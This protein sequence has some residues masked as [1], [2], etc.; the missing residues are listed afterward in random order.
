MKN[1]TETQKMKLKHKAIL[2]G[3]NLMPGDCVNIISGS[4]SA[5]KLQKINIK[6]KARII[7]EMMECGGFVCDRREALE[8]AVYL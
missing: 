4:F 1:F 3:E 6:D 7:I 8:E 5:E 2:F